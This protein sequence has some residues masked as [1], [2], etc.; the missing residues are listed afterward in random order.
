MAATP[1]H[2]RSSSKKGSTRASNRYDKVLTKSKTI[3]KRG[4]KFLA[5]SSQTGKYYPA[6]T[7]CEDNPEYK[8]IKILSKK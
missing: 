3:K 7:V 8:G 4:G 5:V 2:R 6:H 1:K